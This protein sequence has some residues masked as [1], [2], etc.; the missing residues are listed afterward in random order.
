MPRR[1]T[2]EFRKGSWL[3]GDHQSHGFSRD[4]AN[5]DYGQ[6]TEKWLLNLLNARA[7]RNRDIYEFGVYTG[8]RMKDW[9]ALVHGFGHLWGFDSFSGF[10]DE[11]P[12]N[13]V[14][15]KNWR[16]GGD[17]AADALR[18]WNESALF[19]HLR[20]RIGYQNLTFIPGYFNESLTR[21]LRTQHHF[22]P[23][24]LVH[25]DCNMYISTKQAMRWVLQNRILVPSSYL[26]YD[27]WPGNLTKHASQKVIRKWQERGLPLSGYWGQMKAH[28]EVSDEFRV[29]WKRINRNIFELVGVGGAVEHAISPQ[30]VAGCQFPPCF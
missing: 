1:G 24:L 11:A 27:D 29:S 13:A 25:M 3:Q 8:R 26:R 7:S 5:V 19:G 9:A 22:Q 17:S 16:E 2:G 18:M 21:E 20:R 14:P 28:V 4:G 6:R 23:A 30:A 15:S 12:G 10:P